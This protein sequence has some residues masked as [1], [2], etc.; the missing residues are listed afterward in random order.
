MTVTNFAE[1]KA[2]QYED[3]EE[4]LEPED[5]EG[6]SEENIPKAQVDPTYVDQES[7]KALVVNNNDCKFKIVNNAWT[8]N[9][10][11]LWKNFKELQ[12][13]NPATILFVEIEEAKPSY[14]GKPKFCE[15]SVASKFQQEI[16]WQIS[17]K[18][19]T[20]IIKIYG[21]NVDKHEQTQQQMLIHLYNA[22][23]QIKEDGSLRDY[24]IKAFAEVWASLKAGWDKENTPLPSLIDEGSWA[25]MHKL[26]GN[27]FEDRTGEN[28]QAKKF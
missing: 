12:G 16:F 11:A 14:R 21:G 22:M 17:G 9:A 24:D 3:H 6:A 2:Q 23:R 20:H 19:F 18:K 27:L 15:V 26:Q 7:E 10:R 1:M 28:N 5:F 8:P 4:F 13:C 25:R